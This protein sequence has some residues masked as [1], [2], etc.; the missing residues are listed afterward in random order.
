M[1]E[2]IRK[3]QLPKDGVYVFE[4]KEVTLGEEINLFYAK[5]V[6]PVKV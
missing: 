4:R 5:Q 6:D 1:K 2:T 3:T